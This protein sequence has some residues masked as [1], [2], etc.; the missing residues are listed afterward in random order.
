MADGGRNAPG[1]EKTVES[2]A[3]ERRACE[4]GGLRADKHS[5]ENAMVPHRLVQWENK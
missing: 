1:C 3:G 5:G 4:E 2:K